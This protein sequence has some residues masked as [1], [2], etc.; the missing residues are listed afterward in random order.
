MSLSWLRAAASGRARELRVLAEQMSTPLPVRRRIS[1]VSVTDGCGATTVATETARMFS[2]HRTDRVLFVTRADADSPRYRWSGTVKK[3][4]GNHTED[5]LANWA[6]STRGHQLTHDITFTDWGSAPLSHMRAIASHSHALCLVT[7][8]VRRLIQSTLDV[9]AEL[10][11][12]QAVRLAVV[13]VAGEV[14]PSIKD[15]VRNLALPAALLRHDSRLARGRA[16]TVRFREPDA[17]DLYRL[18][19]GLIQDL[20]NGYKEQ[21]A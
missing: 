10:A 4:I 12:Q 18:A 9:G 11:K 2:L 21:T 16:T 8:A 17:L 13:D 3:L 7:P 19:V 20:S 15:V 1:F 5:P 6:E 14:G